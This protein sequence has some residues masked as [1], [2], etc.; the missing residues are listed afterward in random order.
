MAI[1]HGGTFLRC[2]SLLRLSDFARVT[3]SARFILR[4]LRTAAI[5]QAVIG[6]STPWGFNPTTVG[7]L[8]RQISI[9]H[10]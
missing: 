8:S 10:F 1:A 7:A 9:G 3:A 2:K 4:C 5:P 6:A